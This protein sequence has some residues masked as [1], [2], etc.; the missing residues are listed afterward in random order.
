MARTLNG[1]GGTY[2]S[3]LH[4]LHH[5]Q[6]ILILIQVI[7]VYEIFPVA[8]SNVGQFITIDPALSVMVVNNI[9]LHVTVY[10]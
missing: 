5:F 9:K 2:T 8:N 10:L 4:T 1:E 3:I 7:K 6:N